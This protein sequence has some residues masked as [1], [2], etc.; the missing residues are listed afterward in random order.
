LA[1]PPIPAGTELAG[2]RID[3]FLAR[4][5]MGEVYEATQL[6]L[7]RR[8]A[9]KLISSDLGLDPH[10]RERFRR[11]ARAA[12]AIDHP[13]ILPVHE[14]GELPGG[15]LFLAMRYVDGQ[16][17]N[18]CI[19]ENGRLEIRRAVEILT[20]LGDAIDAAHEKGLIHRDVKPEN[21]MLEERSSGTRAYLTDFGLAKPLATGSAPGQT[22]PGQIL[23]TIDYMSPEQVNGLEIDQRV[24]VYA[25]GCVVYRCLTGQLPYARDNDAAKLY[26]H[27]NAEVPLPSAE[28]PDLPGVFDTVVQRAM[29]KDRELRAASAGALM[30]WA[31]DT[32]QLSSTTRP[33][34]PSPT[35]VA[36]PPKERGPRLS[37]KV[38]T[39]LFIA[40]YA[41]LF[42]GAY[43]LGRSI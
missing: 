42:A 7:D 34:G 26:A 3:R 4:G 9:L 22:V 24:D 32:V 19:Q 35:V 36:E 20:Q 31:A 12:A 6:S 39:G 8:V 14:A 37:L 41:P 28:V 30:R 13:N 25:F 17:L 33:G 10:F 5:G 23:G 18:T 38:R 15:R 27:A 16:D 40:V 43:L 11:E 29:E 21:V 1:E 2:Y